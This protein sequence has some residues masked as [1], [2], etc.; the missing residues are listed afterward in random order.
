MAEWLA[1][2]DPPLLTSS[3]DRSSVDPR[4]PAHRTGQPAS[5][6]AELQRPRGACD[7]PS[8]HWNLH[9]GC[10]TTDYRD[11]RPVRKNNFCR[12]P[13]TSARHDGGPK[14]NKVSPPPPLR[15]RFF[16]WFVLSPM[17][18]HLNDSSLLSIFDFRLL[19]RGVRSPMNRRVYQIVP[20]RLYTERNLLESRNIFVVRTLFD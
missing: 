3:A 20:N 10:V 7:W 2:R 14:K 11:K 9:R 17:T 13:K 18:W 16:P 8:W 4:S 12:F 1:P 6:T 19:A 5:F 15:D